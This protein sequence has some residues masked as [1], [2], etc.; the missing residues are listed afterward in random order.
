M[1][2]EDAETN[3]TTTR[4]TTDDNPV[5]IENIILAIY[6]ASN[7]RRLDR[8]TGTFFNPNLHV[9]GGGFFQSV[10]DTAVLY[11]VCNDG[12]IC[13][14][15]IPA[16]IATNLSALDD[17][18]VEPVGVLNLLAALNIGGLGADGSPILQYNGGVRL[19]RGTQQQ[20]V[21]YLTP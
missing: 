16:I 20:G 10:Y 11:F 2:W 14:I 5:D 4:I 19:M 17:A 6:N 12:T 15:A 1:R 7:A 21:T 9:A 8:V 13:P 3:I 18:T